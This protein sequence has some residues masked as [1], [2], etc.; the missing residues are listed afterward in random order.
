MMKIRNAEAVDKA[1]V[2]EF[3]KNTFSWGDYLADVWDSWQSKGGL[4]VIEDDGKVVGVYNISFYEKEAWV[5]GMRVRLQ[6]RKKGFGKRML[7]HAESITPNKIMRLIIES[8]N[9][10]S[11]RLVESM[12]YCLEDKWRLYSMLPEKQDS[13]VEIVRSISQAEDMINSSTYA[14]SWKWL[15]LDRKELQKLIDH[16][17]IVMSVHKRKTLAIGIWN[18]SSDFTQ[19]LQI[20]YVNGTSIGMV[21]ILRYMQNKA[22]ELGCVRIQV[23]VQE[24]IPIEAKFLGKRSLF[25]L[26]RKD[27]PKKNL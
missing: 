23:F 12:G 9:N 5:E 6:Y 10:P 22:H 4:H 17:R 27:L 13:D 21:D 3:C 18:R 8:E 25:Y 1:T 24:K 20:G 2:L 15:P 11:I 16:K 19:V 14:D 7:E 26:M